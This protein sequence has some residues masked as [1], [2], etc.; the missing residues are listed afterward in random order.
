MPFSLPAL[1]RPP[2]GPRSVRALSLHL[3]LVCA[4]LLTA[5]LCDVSHARADDGRD[6]PRKPTAVTPVTPITP[7]APVAPVSGVSDLSGVPEAAVLG[8]Q[9]HRHPQTHC[10]PSVVTRSAVDTQRPSPAV[11]GLP[12]VVP[13]RTATAGDLPG[14]A[15]EACAARTERSGRSTLT[16]VCRWRI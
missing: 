8:T 16:A 13:A 6:A 2:L 10:L 5:L 15:R 14:P 12:A 4:V 1:P 9:E 3:L 11:L 7:V